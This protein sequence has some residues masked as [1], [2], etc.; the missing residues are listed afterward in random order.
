MKDIVASTWRHDEQLG[1]GYLLFSQSHHNGR[2]WRWEVGGGPIAIGRSL[3]L[4]SSG[5]RSSE[6]QVCHN[7]GKAN[8]SERG[9]DILSVGS[10]G[11]AI[12]FHHAKGT[13]HSEGSLVVAEWGEGRIIRMEDNGARTPLMIQVPDICSTSSTTTTRLNQP[14]SL[15]YTPY[16]DLLVAD[17]AVHCSK[18]AI[19]RLTQAVQ[20]EAVPSLFES[21]KAH[22]W[23]QT[24]HD[25]PVDLLYHASI[26]DIGG[27]A[28]DPTW[29]YIYITVLDAEGRV[30]LTRLPA[31]RLEDDDEEEEPDTDKK[32]R[33]N[34]SAAEE[35][36]A[37]P[38]EQHAESQTAHG[39]IMD[40]KGQAILDLTQAVG[41]TQPGPLAVSDKGHLFL[42]VPQGIAIVSTGESHGSGSAVVLG[43]LPMPAPPTSL[44][45]GE[46]K[47]LYAFTHYSL[48]R[49]RVQVGPV[50]VPTNLVVGKETS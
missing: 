39:G 37:T 26:R 46:D 15:I 30:Q 44:T 33:P 23:N 49:I 40:N 27:M 50:M 16:G 3:H 45:L 17:T 29:L 36:E 19:Y 21:R 9:R 20:V 43:I 6:Y 13:R 24:Q 32:K 11:M 48:F 34:L 8:S 25:L 2:I 10:G 18:A 7:D 41:S 47:F 38:G 22:E 31:V 4:E 35:E 28:I 5:C 14:R 42:A 1:R 12:D